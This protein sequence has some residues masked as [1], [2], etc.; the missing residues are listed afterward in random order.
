MVPATPDGKENTGFRS[1]FTRYSH[2]TA[3]PPLLGLIVF[4][5]R[6]HLSSNYAKSIFHLLI[7]ILSYHCW[8]IAIRFPKVLKPSH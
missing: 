3:P 5:S 2:I 7:R 4:I 6:V 8:M 1:K